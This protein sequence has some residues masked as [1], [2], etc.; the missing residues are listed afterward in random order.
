MLHLRCVSAFDLLPHLRPGNRFH[1]ETR[2][3]TLQIVA[4]AT[5]LMLYNILAGL[6]AGAVQGE[7]VDADELCQAIRAQLA[8][9]TTPEAL[10]AG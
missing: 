1:I 3:S 2:G 4:D 10:R 9:P 6:E 5:P 8:D 7:D